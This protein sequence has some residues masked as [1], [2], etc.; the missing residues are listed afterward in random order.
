M[1]YDLWRV[2]SDGGRAEA[3][4]E[5]VGDVGTDAESRYGGVVGGASELE[6][7]SDDCDPSVLSLGVVR[8][9][10]GQDSCQSG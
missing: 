6:G 2:G 4:A 3:R 5:D 7:A 8:R 1:N 9:Q 10:S